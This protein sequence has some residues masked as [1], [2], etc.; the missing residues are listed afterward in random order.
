MSL[1]AI[2]ER[3]TLDQ[4]IRHARSFGTEC[5]YETGEQEG[6]SSADLAAYVS[7]WM[8]S[9]PAAS[10][11]TVSASASED[12][13]PLKRLELPLLLSLLMGSCRRR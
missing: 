6:L 13:A 4:L 10:P 5:V 2:L 8:N 7:S 11:G 12:D 3:A 1:S 9:R